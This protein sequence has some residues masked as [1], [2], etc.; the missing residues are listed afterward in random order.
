MG[1]VVL[2]A[3]QEGGAPV[4]E[5]SQKFQAGLPRVELSLLPAD[6]E[7]IDTDALMVLR[8]QLVFLMPQ[9]PLPK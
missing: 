6:C 3:A 5:K 7:G 4:P 8:L 9:I 2:Y 1:M